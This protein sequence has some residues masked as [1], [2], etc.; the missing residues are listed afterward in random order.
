MRSLVVLFVAVVAGCSGKGG[1]GGGGG[2]SLS[3]PESGV[4]TYYDATG[5]GA[6][7]FDPSPGD[8]DVAAIDAPEWDGSGMCGA[9]AQVSG[10][11]GAITVRIVDL[12]PECERG[13]L[14]L[15]MQAFA[16]IAD[17]AAGRVPITWQIVPCNVQGNVSYRYKDGSSQ[18]WTAIQVLNHRLPIAR[19]EAQLSG[20]WQDVPRSDYDYFVRQMGVGTTGSFQVRVTAVDGQTV[21]DTLPPVSSGGVA[22]GHAQFQ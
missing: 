5:A 3:T 21:V 2:P 18:Y 7:S 8:L 10:P 1:S 6:C 13:H 15:S 4:A 14:D 17:V 16:K 19:L 12:C 20:T 11:N 9:C 22:Y